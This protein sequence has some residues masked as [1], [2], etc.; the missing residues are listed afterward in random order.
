M[1]PILF[2]GPLI[3]P[4]LDGTKTQTRRLVTTRHSLEHI[5]PRGSQDDP[6][7]W[8]Y[9]FD[10]PAHHGWMVLGRGHNE[11][12]DHGSISIPCPYGEVGDRL[13]VRETWRTAS[14]FDAISPSMITSKCLE[15][16]YDKAW[17]PAKW[18]ADG[19][20]GGGI[21]DFGGAWGKL[22]PSIFMPRWAS[23]ITLEVTDVRVQ[24]LQE[25]SEDDARSEGCAPLMIGGHLEHPS[26]RRGYAALWDQINGK[27]RRREY[28]QLGEFGYPG[29]RVTVID[30]STRWDANPWVWAVTFKRLP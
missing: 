22:R 1:K 21:D 19:K 8:G 29:Y 26:Y 16:G 20:D 28:L 13:W 4:L 12:H 18:E 14:A 3:Q 24:R 7:A 10:G 5:G 30:E 9:F 6:D 25:I 27:R 2:S 23:R 11:Q 15:A 17:G